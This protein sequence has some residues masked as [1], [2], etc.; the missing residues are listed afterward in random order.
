MVQFFANQ[1]KTFEDI[2]ARKPDSVR[3]YHDRFV[4]TVYMRL[5]CVGIDEPE[6]PARMKS[7]GR[8]ASSQAE[9]KTDRRFA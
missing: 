2:L 3:T 8:L 9:R 7:K 4:G 5:S 1:R 6:G